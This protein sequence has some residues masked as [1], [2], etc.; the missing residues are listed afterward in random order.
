M[1]H[2]MVLM[3]AIFKNYLLEVHRSLLIV[4]LLAIMIVSN[5]DYLVGKCLELYW[6]M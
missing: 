3:I 6:E 2:L 4:T 1:D 5:C